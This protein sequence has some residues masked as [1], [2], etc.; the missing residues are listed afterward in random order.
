MWR[1]YIA[2]T[3]QLEGRL[4]LNSTLLRSACCLHPV[5]RT[6]SN[7]IPLVEALAKHVPQVV[8][9]TKITEVKVEWS[10]NIAGKACSV[11]PA[12]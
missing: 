10:W 2:T 9:E 11:P 8:G 6:Q 7:T 4:C 1:F 12:E 3:K 5:L